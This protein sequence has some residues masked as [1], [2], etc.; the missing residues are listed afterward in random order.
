ML[1]QI[2]NAGWKKQAVSVTEKQEVD[3]K[4]EGVNCHIYLSRYADGEPHCGGRWNLQVYVGGY[5]A[6]NVST[7]GMVASAD[8]GMEKAARMI[9][10]LHAAY[11][12]IKGG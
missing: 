6:F 8:E 12:A 1:E 4:Y 7:S 11:I 2:K 9:P 3:I 5:S 10:H